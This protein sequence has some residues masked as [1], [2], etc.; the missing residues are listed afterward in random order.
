MRSGNE[1]YDADDA[2]D[3]LAV[4][5]D[6][7]GVGVRLN[8]HGVVAA[9]DA[10]VAASPYVIG[11]KK[12]VGQSPKARILHFTHV[13]R[14]ITHAS[15]VLHYDWHLLQLYNSKKMQKKS[16]NYGKNLTRARTSL[17]EVFTSLYFGKRESIV[18][19]LYRIINRRNLSRSC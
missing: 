12:P 7:D 1:L 17:P 4:A 5:A 14:T 10:Q 16:E 19:L 3:G 8:L 6:G 9:I 2:R 11:Y 18:T 13:E 15:L